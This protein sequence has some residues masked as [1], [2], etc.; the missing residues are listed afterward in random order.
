MS[1]HVRSIRLEELPRAHDLMHAGGCGLYEGVVIGVGAVL[2][3]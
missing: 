2:G 3:S 1:L